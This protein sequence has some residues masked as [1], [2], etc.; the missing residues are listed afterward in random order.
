MSVLELP[1][2][3]LHALRDA[4]VAEGTDPAGWVAARLAER[5]A[6]PLAGPTLAEAFAGRLGRVASGGGERLSEDGGRRLADHLE[7][8][9]QAGAMLDLQCQ[10]HSTVFTPK[11]LHN[12]A[13]GR[14]SRTPG[15]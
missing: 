14:A 1:G 5:R 10:P 4:A 8:E 11:G 9:R 15:T 7:A 12:T 6:V 2:P 13:R 3:I